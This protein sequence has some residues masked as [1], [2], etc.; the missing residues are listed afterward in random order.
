MTGA[1]LDVPSVQ[2]G[3]HGQ[4]HPGCR[5]LSAGQAR[6]GGIRIPACQGARYSPWL[7]L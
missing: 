2:L 5:V 6:F 7:D 3:N 1:S 4:E